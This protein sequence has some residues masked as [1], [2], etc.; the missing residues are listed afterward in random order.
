M[1]RPCAPSRVS[2]CTPARRRAAASCWSPA[3]RARS[4]SPTYPRPSAR[5]GS[6][7]GRMS[8]RPGGA[9]R[10][11]GA[12]AEVALEAARAAAERGGAS[13]TGELAGA[14]GAA[15][16]NEATTA[17]RAAEWAAEVERLRIRAEEA[18]QAATRSRAQLHEQE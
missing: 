12:R 16:A 14:R 1:R 3:R 13:G 18:E 6:V 15:A 10:A 5:S 4:P 7:P 2:R 17:A 8:A 11:E 9:G